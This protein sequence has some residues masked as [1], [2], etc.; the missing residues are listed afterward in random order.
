[1]NTE[2]PNSKAHSI[3]VTKI[4]YCLSQF[5]DITFVCNRITSS[6][7]NLYIDIINQYGIDLSRVKFE[8]IKKKK[9]TGISFLFSL[10]K[11]LSLA[12]KNTV[13]YTRSY[14]LAKRL[15]RTKFIHKKCVILE[16]HKKS[17]YYKED[18]VPSSVYEK[19]RKSFEIDNKNK[20]TLQRIY[21]MVDGV[22]FTSLESKKIVEKDLGLQNTEYIWH[23]LFPHI[24]DNRSRKGVVYSGSLGANKLIELL[25]DALVA[26][27]CDVVVEMIGGSPQ[28]I[29]RVGKEAECRGVGRNLKFHDRVPH[30][31]LPDFL[32]RYKYGLSLMEGLKVSDYVECGLVP[33]IPRI[34]MYTEIFSQDSAVF[35]EPDNAQHLGN[36]LA[37]F[38]SATT[39]ECNCN[40]ILDEY[41]ATK[42]AKKIL[43][44]ANNCTEV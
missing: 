20:K 33:I 35:F 12:S 4:L 44:L 11:I 21:K 24:C 43:S 25:L 39:P 27:K 37:S 38:D 22:T 13:F 19:Q 40:A 28:D 29:E 9:L 5:T 2:Y 3:Q 41:S 26:A 18:S 14:S 6:R 36:I 7:E 31:A 10:I 23:P 30:R 15:S 34:P 16:S 42:T 8:E 17:G 1:M 32:S